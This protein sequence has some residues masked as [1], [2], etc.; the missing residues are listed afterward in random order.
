M[1]DHITIH[2]PPGALADKGLTDFMNLLGMHE[3]VPGESVPEGWG[4]RWFHDNSGL[5]PTVHLVEGDH[6]GVNAD[7]LVLGHFCVKVPANR[8]E[9]LR[10]S[11]WCV[12]A[13][14]GS[15][16]IWVQFHNVRVEVRSL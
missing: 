10:K 13:R 6:E 15:A 8:V 7:D 4:I 5:W 16:R 1:I 9:A 2:V 11:R 3:L 12:R 14:L